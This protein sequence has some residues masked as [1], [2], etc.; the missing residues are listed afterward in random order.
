MNTTHDTQTLYADSVIY[1][2]YLPCFCDGLGEGVGNVEG[3]T[4]KLDYL[5]ELGVNTLLIE[6]YQVGIGAESTQDASLAALLSDCKAKGLQVLLDMP[7]ASTAIDHPWF[8]QSAEGSAEFA[9]YYA[10]SVGRGNGKAAPEGKRIDGEPIWR[11]YATGKWYRQYLGRPMLNLAFT[12]VR[13][14]IVEAARRYLFLGVNGFVWDVR[15]LLGIDEKDKRQWLGDLCRDV[16]LQN[17]ACIVVLRAEGVAPDELQGYPFAS[18]ITATTIM[19]RKPT[20]RKS[21]P[22]VRNFKHT[23]STLQKAAF[24]RFV[25]TLYAENASSPRCLST[26]GGE[27]GDFR[28]EAV[29]S[30]AAATT[31]LYGAAQVYQGQEIGMQNYHFAHAADIT[32]PRYYRMTHTKWTR[33]APVD[34]LICKAVSHSAA[35]NARTAMQWTGLLPNAGF[36]TSRTPQVFVNPNY[37]EINVQSSMENETGTVHFFRKLFALRKDKSLSPAFKYGTYREYYHGDKNLYVYTRSYKG[38][39]IIVVC[40]LQNAY[41]TFSVPNDLAFH[42]AEL[43]LHN[44]DMPAHLGNATL[45]PYE[46]IVYRLK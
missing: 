17:P 22:N 41:V 18:G 31:L 34:K 11:Q 3:L 30:I 15:Y 32:D 6:G 29:T 14:A 45:R 43:L 10:W 8:A 26:I 1:H 44:Y 2:V 36:S 37:T 46:C 25:P 39:T 7:I 33:L 24:G 40:N 19:P 42:Q 4:S 21:K 20:L 5:A 9:D 38:T 16:R 13:T 28:K 35:D 27:F 12:P 23:L